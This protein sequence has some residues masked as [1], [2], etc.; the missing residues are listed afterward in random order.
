MSRNL[1]HQNQHHVHITCNAREWYIP[2]NVQSQ[3]NMLH[4]GIAKQHHDI[5]LPYKQE[6]SAEKEIEKKSC[7][8]AGFELGTFGL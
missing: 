3:Y 7:P 1:V 5:L 6:V 4:F 8:Q 2:T